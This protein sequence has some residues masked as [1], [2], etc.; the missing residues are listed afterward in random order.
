MDRRTGSRPRSYRDAFV[1]VATIA[2]LVAGCSSPQAAPTTAPA[3]KPAAT[4]A[5]AAVSSPAA[6]ASP[7]VAASPVA[8]PAAAASPAASPA[9]AASPI[10]AAPAPTVSG[11]AI[12]VRLA[13]SVPAL[14]F[15]PLLAARD[16][17]YFQQQGV[18][19]KYV[20]LQSGATA[21]QAIIGG[22]VDVTDSASTE[23][24][25]A[26]GQGVPLMAIQNTVMM[27]LEMCA[28]K[29]LMDKA[30]VTPSS[31]L[32]DRMA[33]FKG[34]TLGI[35]GPGAVS[36]RLTRWLLQK[37]GGLDPNKDVQITQVGGAAAMA[38][39]LQQNRIQGYLLS[40]PNCEQAGDQAEVL[41]KPSDVPEWQNYVHEVLY[42]SKDWASKNKEA[43]TRTATAVSMGN[44]Y[45]LQHPDQSIALMQ[46]DFNSIDPKIIEAAMR[47]VILPAVRKDG[48]MSEDMWTATNTVLQE[49]GMIQ[50]P[51]DIKEGGIWTNEYIGNANVP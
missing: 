38:G 2:V 36:D 44:N 45:L 9:A 50:K 27:T 15:A 29:D 11:P 25:A 37:Y 21:E 7:A 31:P 10:A 22:S 49:A 14:S 32:K 18:D 43:A 46:K 13:Q 19:L 30:G 24:A 41:I 1:G 26:V 39:A 28:R 42:T 33:A 51:L 35:T 40:P 12:T 8:S 23:V 5:P 4:T 34:A 17:G 47:N 20:E 16:L 6:A 3:T 48:K